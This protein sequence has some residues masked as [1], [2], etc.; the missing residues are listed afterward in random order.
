MRDEVERVAAHSTKWVMPCLWVS[1]PDFDAVDEALAADP[2]VDDIVQTDE[3]DSEKYYRMK[4]TDAVNRRIDTFLDKE[5]SILDASVTADG[6]RV[7]IR[8][9]SRDQFQKFRNHFRGRSYSFDLLSMTEP[10][11]P[12]QM[13]AE[14]TPDQ[15][16]ALVLAV[17]CG[18]YDV[19][20]EA[21]TRVLADELGTSHQA[22]SELLRRGVT[23]L[24][25][26]TIATCEGVG[27]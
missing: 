9:A 23:N 20:R 11:A 15:R 27:S 16:D 24:V 10:G 1:G 14:V 13:S 12:R 26:S 17:E 4:W 2:D 5:G 3:F 25:R 7:R 22:V 19:P 8:F 18:Y 21:S 6:W